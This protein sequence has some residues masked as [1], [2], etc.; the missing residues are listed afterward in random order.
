MKKPKEA[1]KTI[2]MYCMC[3]VSIFHWNEWG[4]ILEHGTQFSSY[5]GGNFLQQKFQKVP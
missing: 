1:W 3:T 5:I 2:L 4:T